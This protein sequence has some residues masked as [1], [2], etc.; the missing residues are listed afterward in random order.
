MN[1]AWYGA[2][3]SFPKAVQWHAWFDHW[4]DRIDRMDPYERFLMDATVKIQQTLVKIGQTVRKNLEWTRPY[5]EGE[6]ANI[7]DVAEEAAAWYR[8]NRPSK[9]RIRALDPVLLILFE[10]LDGAYAVTERLAQELDQINR[11]GYVL[12][13]TSQE[14]KELAS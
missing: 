10:G 14:L 6:M 13:D 5:T 8:K 4:K 11:K 9:D 12:V 3:A 1:D 2:G 7:K